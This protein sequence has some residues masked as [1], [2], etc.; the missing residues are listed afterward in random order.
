MRRKGFTLV[1]LMVVLSITAVLG[2]LGLAG[3][4]NYNKTQLLQTSTNEVVGILNLAKSRAQSQIKP[5]DCVGNLEGYGVRISLPN[6][7]ALFFRCTDN[8]VESQIKLLPSRL[9][10]GVDA[11]F[12]FPVLVGGANQAGQITILSSDSNSQKIIE[13]DLPGRIIIKQ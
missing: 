3:F 11:I 13:I 4:A 1:E 2:A 5:S 8:E 6:R 12:F 9:E 10:F 7:Y